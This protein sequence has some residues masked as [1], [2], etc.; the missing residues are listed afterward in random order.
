MI[1]TCIL[2]NY[3]RCNPRDVGHQEIVLQQLWVD[4]LIP[5]W[6]IEMYEAGHVKREWRDV[7]FEKESGL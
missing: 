3:L 2:R 7:P 4:M 6:N 5:H 1:P